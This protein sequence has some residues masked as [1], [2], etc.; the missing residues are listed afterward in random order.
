MVSVWRKTK[1]FV[2]CF[3]DA[4]FSPVLSGGASCVPYPTS[5]YQ[6]MDIQTA[7]WYMGLGNIKPADQFDQN[8]VYLIG[9]VSSCQLVL[10]LVGCSVCW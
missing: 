4:L 3:D 8:A 2:S 10:S 7:R 9:K 1:V 6:A 5:P